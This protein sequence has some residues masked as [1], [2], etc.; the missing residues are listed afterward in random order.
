MMGVAASGLLVSA[1]A[2]AVEPE[3]ASLGLSQARA[4]LDRGDL[5]GAHPGLAAAAAE[6]LFE[7]AM[8]ERGEARAADLARA[9][10][11]SP[12]GHWVGPAAAG[13]TLLVEEKGAEA[14]AK[15]RQA[16]AANGTD[17][18]LHKLLGDT[19]RAE[20]DSAG[21][22]AAYNAAVALDPGYSS[23]L[24]AVGDLDR[25]AGD[26]AAAFNAFN[27]A[28]DEQ[29]RPVAALLGRAAARLYLGD[30]SGA[31]ADLKQAVAGSAPGND[32]YRALMSFVYAHTYLAQTARGTRPGRA[33]AWRC[34]RVWVALKWPL[35][36]ATPSDACC[37]RPAAATR[38][39]TGTTAAGQS[40]KA[41]R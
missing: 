31:F 18:R 28:L 3:A 21:A 12:A 22:L 40:C 2:F 14:T 34:G 15:L 11:L 24:L 9:G 25:R 39:S 41:R 6:S 20:G 23:A 17:K 10:A 16:L 7:L 36:P 27:H 37:S 4:A 8:S 13:L 29:N 32:R 33:G 35:P 38:R 5:D 30:E 26:F 19:L 1:T